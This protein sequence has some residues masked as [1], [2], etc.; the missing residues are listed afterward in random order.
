[1]AAIQ[2]LELAGV[3]CSVGRSPDKFMEAADFAVLGAILVQECEI[4]FVEFLEELVPFDV[5]QSFILWTEIDP[6]DARVPI[7]FSRLDCRRTA[8]PVGRPF[9]DDIMVGSGMAFA[10]RCLRN[11]LDSIERC[12]GEET[13][14]VSFRSY[15]GTRVKHH[16]HHHLLPKRSPTTGPD[17]ILD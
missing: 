10:H 15:D 6:K 13:R 8:L 14:L 9:P 7:V 5:V 4:G 17:S 12:I 2:S 3:A 11:Q 1:M 16:L